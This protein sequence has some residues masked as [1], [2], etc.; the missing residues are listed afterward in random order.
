MCTRLTQDGRAKL[1][2]RLFHNTRRETS[3][4]RIEQ[5]VATAE[6]IAAT[7]DVRARRV[8][9]N[10]PPAISSSATL[11]SIP[12]DPDWFMAEVSA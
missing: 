11:H 6:A 1:K 5:L 2:L 7:N 3:D 9:L 8:F 12:L 10:V 4:Q